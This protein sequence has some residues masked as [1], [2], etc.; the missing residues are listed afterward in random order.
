MVVFSMAVLLIVSL[1]IMLHVSRKA[2]KD[3]AQQKAMQT[4]EGTIQRIDNILLSV[5]QSAGNQ[6]YNMLP[7][8]NNPDKV[9]A[10]CRKLVESNSYI[11]GCAIAFKPYFYKDREHFMAYFH[12]SGKGKD[13][14]NTPIIQSETFGGRSYTEQVWFKKPM[15]TGRAGWLNPLEDVDVADVA[16]ITFCIPI[17]DS[18]GKPVGSISVDVSLYVLSQIIH[19]VKPSR[20]SYC[21][22]LSDDGRIILHPD[23]NKLYKQA[24]YIDVGESFTPSMRQA[25]ETMI[26]GRTGYAPFNMK[27]NNYFIFYKPFKRTVVPGRSMEKM[28]WSVGIIYPENDIFGDYKRLIYYV[29]GIAVVGLLLLFIFCRLIIHH[30]LQPLVLLT[31][32]AQRIADGDYDDIIPDSHQQDEIGSLQN[33][34]QQMQKSLAANISELEGLKETLQKRGEELSKALYKTKQAD[35]MKTAFLHNMSNKMASPADS[36]FWDVETLCDFDR[37]IDEETASQLADDIKAKG[38]H[39]AKLLDDLLKVS[40]KETKEGGWL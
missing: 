35:R 23:S 28:A 25:A 36:I 14:Y 8:L 10:Y 26:S 31:K 17:S 7:Y 30:Q 6:Y 11:D 32:S 2:I 24:V 37:G 34:F 21:A 19:A 13:S 38:E 5:E 1:S 18:E 4:L 20:N 29:S 33:H 40:E 39:I 15:E 16:L 9:T 3:E 12:H 27:G 22:L